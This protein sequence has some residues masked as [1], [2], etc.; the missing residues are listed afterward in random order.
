[1]LCIQKQIKFLVMDVDGTLTDGKIYMGDSGE[2]MKAFDIKDGSGIL[3]ILPKCGVIP[4]IITARKSEILKNRCKELNVLELHQG[5][6]DKI[7]ELEK[8]LSDFSTRDGCSY[9]LKN[10]AYI[11]DDILDIQ[12]MKL[13]QEAGGLAVC[14]S[15]AAREVIDSASFVCTKK[16]GEGAI[17]EFIEWLAGLRS[18]DELEKIRV[19][20][21]VAYDFITGFNPSTD[22]DG[23]YDLGDGVFANVI[24]YITKEACLTSY[25]THKKYI[26]IQYMIYGAEIMMVQSAGELE[27]CISVPYNEAKDATLYDSNAGKVSIL[28]PGGSIV[29][30]PNDAHRGTMLVHHPTPVR[31]IIVKVPVSEGLR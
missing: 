5:V 19:V 9:S 31:K 18:G 27:N 12:C 8:I 7:G 6:T 3:L 4:V 1:M 25:E 13:I 20:S 24:S 17:R 11:G 28:D 15:D 2:M 16:G 26:D 14:P 30:Y 22:G 29:L 23:R 10:V 21:P